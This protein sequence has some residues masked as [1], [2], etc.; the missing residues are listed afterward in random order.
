MDISVEGLSM[1]WR[2]G[3]SD[4]CGM[5]PPRI[6]QVVKPGHWDTGLGVGWW[7]RWRRERSWSDL[8]VDGSEGL[9]RGGSRVECVLD[10]VLL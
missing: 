7:G 9:V 2:T 3:T 8:D 10:Y 1:P 4:F 5:F 6:A